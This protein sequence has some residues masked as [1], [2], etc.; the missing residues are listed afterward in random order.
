MPEFLMH[1]HAN[2]YLDTY[3]KLKGEI[4]RQCHE[5][6]EI[7]SPASSS[8]PALF[9]TNFSNAEIPDISSS[10]SS[11]TISNTQSSGGSGSAIKDKVEQLCA[12]MEQ[13][14]NKIKRKMKIKS[15]TAGVNSPSSQGRSASSSLE[16]GSL[17]TTD[18]SENGGPD[19]FSHSS[20]K[21]GACKVKEG[22]GHSTTDETS[23]KSTNNCPHV[24]H[25]VSNEVSQGNELQ[26]YDTNV[27][28]RHVLVH[29]VCNNDAANNG[30][31]VTNESLLENANAV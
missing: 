8:M 7:N 28:G 21:Q 11:T 17:F 6:S 18:S 14:G 15:A 30:N 20:S 12:R 24:P 23:A 2:L 5:E 3:S 9:S 25:K 27:S 10:S 4:Q 22:L 19:N 1:S 31:I 13:V 16:D 26:Q 29:A